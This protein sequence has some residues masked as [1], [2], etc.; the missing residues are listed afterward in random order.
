[1]S[2]TVVKHVPAVRSDNLGYFSKSTERGAVKDPIAISL[3]RIPMIAVRWWAVVVQALETVV[4]AH[5]TLGRN[6][7]S[8]DT[9]VR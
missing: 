3:E 1:M 4:V 7:N 2:E 5:P 8:E 6:G 9:I